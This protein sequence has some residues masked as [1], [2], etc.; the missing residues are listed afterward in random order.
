LTS[1][2]A[3]TPVP[4]TRFV[5][6]RA[7]IAELAALLR[8]R[9][10]VTITG[11][12]GCG[13]TRLAIEVLAGAGRGAEAAAWADLATV[14]DPSLVAPA[15][16]DAVGVPV[17]PTSDPSTAVA[18]GLGERELLVCFDNCEHVV[19]GV[20]GLAERVLASCPQVSVLA[21]SREP[22]G[23]AAETVWRVP[24]MSDAD[25]V[26]LFDERARSARADF[27]LDGTNI[28][29]VRTIC[30]RLDGIP[31][32]VELA[33][34]W[35]RSL[36]PAQIAGALDDRFR[37]LV[38]SHGRALP[39]HRTLRAS[40]DW[41]YG[42]LG[43][44]TRTLL[45]RLSVF[46]GAFTLDDVLAVCPDEDLGPDETLPALT[47]LV[48]TSMINVDA[49]GAVA[50]YELS[51]TIRDYGNG[52]LTD[53][54]L[55]ALRGR[56]LR[57]FSEAAAA[58]A[59]GLDTGDQDAALTRLQSMD[60]DLQAALAWGSVA[61]ETARG[62]RLAADLARMWFLRGRTREGLDALARA[63]DRCP[64]DQ[65]SLRARLWA[66][67]ALVAMPAG[68]M[69]LNSTAS[70]AA[71]ELA[72]AIGDGRTL[73]EATAT[74]GYVPFYSDYR[75]CEELGLAAQAHG[76]ESGDAFA[77]DFGLLLQAVSLANRDRHAEVVPVADE[78]YERPHARHDRVGAFSRNVRLYGALLTGDLRGAVAFGQAA[79]E[80]ARP[81]RDYFVHGTVTSDLAWAVGVAGELDRARRLIEPL[82]RSI[83]R[84][85][86]D[87][88]VI[89]LRVTAR[90][91]LSWSGEYDEALPWLRRAAEFDSPGADN[92][93]AMRALPELAVVLHQLGRDDEAAAAAERGVEMARRLGTPHAEAESLDALARVVA[94]ADPARA[95]GLAH[96]ALR[97][98]SQHGLRTHLADSLDSLARLGADRGDH[99]PAARLMGA[100][101]ESRRRI[102][103][104]RPPADLPTDASLRE[105]LVAVLG[106]ATFAALVGE[107]TDLGLDQA[108]R[109]GSR[110]RGPRRRPAIGWHSLTATER[111]VAALVAEGLTNPQI[112]ERLFVRPA[113]VKTHVSHIFAKVGV[114]TRAELAAL[115]TRERDERPSR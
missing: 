52:L 12:G 101:D 67:Q 108:V 5:G 114:S 111:E 91:L 10:L 62:C 99:A 35:V 20:A 93:T 68:R 60:E 32:A 47:R 78:L 24:P 44:A 33:A 76:R 113:T 97:L 43:D 54:A 89:G 83:D 21:T 110:G 81:L 90:K 63:L 71:I 58:A 48:D 65:P 41:S 31:L 4:L 57:H 14:N 66:A 45:P 100:A 75:R 56:H 88:D 29:A 19:A 77:V 18:S 82:V 102:G 9:R 34:A 30:R 42:L 92:W 98:R 40:V 109:Y 1:T 26:A 7:E 80:L 22:L 23:S 3:V 8:D 28:D 37:V 27:T 16:A 61:A 46:A 115:A 11:P 106:E 25:V 15:A 105:D 38:G 103:Y 95:D 13:K 73:A 72:T 85:G 96:D 39:R 36:T 79:V 55:T 49:T 84:A 69:E 64:E 107:G 59:V 70:G 17:G 104:P 2:A 87:V 86:P 50:H 51:E 53:D 74:A 94:G 112:A 6:R